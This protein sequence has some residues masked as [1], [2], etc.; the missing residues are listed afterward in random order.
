MKLRLSVGSDVELRTRRTN[1]MNHASQKACWTIET[2]LDQ[3]N[4]ARRLMKSSTFGLGLNLLLFFAV[5]VDVVF[6]GNIG[7]IV[8]VREEFELSEFELTK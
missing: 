1:Q 6:K 5:L 8:R 7:N 4:W 3:L 2:H